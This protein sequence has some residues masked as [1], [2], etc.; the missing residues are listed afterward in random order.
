MASGA[1]V[2]SIACALSHGLGRDRGRGPAQTDSAIASSAGNTHADFR[3]TSKC[4]TACVAVAKVSDAL[5]SLAW[6]TASC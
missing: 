4:H 5:Q 6:N 2:G 1:K 3:G